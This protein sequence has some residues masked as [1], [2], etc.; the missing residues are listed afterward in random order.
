[1]ALQREDVPV[2][3]LVLGPALITL[4]VTLVRLGGELLNWAPTFFSREAGGAGAIVGIVWL[5][6]IF[7]VYFALKLL[8]LGHGP[9][10]VGRAIGIPVL[11]FLLVPA[12]IFVAMEIPLPIRIAVLGVGCIVALLVAFRAWPALARTL[13]AYGLAARIPVVIVMLVAILANWGTHYELGPP[14]FPEMAAIPKWFWIGLLP[15]LTLW[16]AFTV[17]VGALFGGVAVLVTGRRAAPVAG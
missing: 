5:V 6:P 2:K 15:Q 11:A 17:I 13:F 3:S 16:M 4:F 12:T 8:R 14:G 10:S 1:M 9:D 7:G